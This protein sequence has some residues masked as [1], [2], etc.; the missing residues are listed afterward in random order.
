M[1]GYFVHTCYPAWAYTPEVHETAQI[2]A[3]VAGV[4]TEEYLQLKVLGLSKRYN[5]MSG[6]IARLKGV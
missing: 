3:V 2:S 5:E 4:T 1:P 6:E